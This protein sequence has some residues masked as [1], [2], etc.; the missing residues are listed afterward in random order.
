[1][2][3]VMKMND[4]KMVICLCL[5]FFFFNS[6]QHNR[7]NYSHSHFFNVN[8]C[9]FKLF[10][11]R[12]CSLAILKNE[13]PLQRM[14]KMYIKKCSCNTLFKT[15]LALATWKTIFGSSGYKVRNKWVHHLES[16]QQLFPLGSAQTKSMKKPEFTTCFGQ[17][18]IFPSLGFMHQTQI[19]IILEEC[20][21]K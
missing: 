6:F 18:K 11:N 19:T 17:V 8:T 14:S 12:C 15:F 21:Q 2:L 1:M 4:G 3:A 16:Y 9:S 5:S 20:M 7:I 10:P 13:S